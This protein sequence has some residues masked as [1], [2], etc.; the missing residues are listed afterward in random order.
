MASV[1]LPSQLLKDEQ[2]IEDF[3]K[4]IE[5]LVK[6]KETKTAKANLDTWSQFETI[7]M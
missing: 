7:E 2:P 5:T 4:R 6:E 1:K 3:V